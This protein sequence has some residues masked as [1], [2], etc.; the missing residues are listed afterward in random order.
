MASISCVMFLLVTAWN[1]LA[2]LEASAPA[3]ARESAVVAPRRG[4]GR[5][6]DGGVRSRLDGPYRQKNMAR[7]ARSCNM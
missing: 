1:R 5:H 7:A 2:A 3:P 6:R 4:D